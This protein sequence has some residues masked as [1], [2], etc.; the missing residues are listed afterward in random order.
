[1]QGFG[2]AGL[3]KGAAVFPGAPWG[4]EPVVAWAV[5]PVHVALST[6]AH[7]DG[8]WAQVRGGWPLGGLLGLESL[9]FP[10]PASLRG[11]GLVSPNLQPG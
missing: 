2:V 7:L 1:M 10:K 5:P 6:V 3:A 9:W 11:G 4:A 8:L